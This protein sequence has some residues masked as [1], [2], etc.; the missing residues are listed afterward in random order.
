[1]SIKSFLI[2]QPIETRREKH[3]RLSKITG[4]AIFASD[5]LSSSA[6]ATEEIMLALI[7]AGSALLSFAVPIAISIAMLL[8]IIAVSYFQ[9]IHAYPSG[10]GA[11][12]VAKDNLGT[13]T[14]LVAGAA[15]LIDY[16][17]TVSVSIAAGVAA[18]TSA[19]PFL[20]EYR[21]LLGLIA[22]AGLM[23]GNLRG[24]REA[25]KMFFLPTY[26]FILSLF[27]LIIVG[28]VKAFTGT[29]PAPAAP[30]ETASDYIALFIILRAFASG[31]AAVTGIEAVSNG[32]R[33]FRPPE[34]RNASLT[35]IAMASILGTLFI[36]ISYLANHFHI[37][38]AENETM[39]SQLAALIFSKGPFYYSVQAATAMILILAANTS[40]QDFP[41]LSSVMA[42][43]GFMPRQ[44]GSRG[45]RLVFSNGIVILSLF[46]AAL[47]VLFKGDTHALI[48]LYAVGVFLAITLSQAGM[49]RHWLDPRGKR[50]LRNMLIN[51]MGATAT[52]V[53]TVIIAST[54]FIHGA[55]IVVIAIPILVFLMMKVN[56]HYQAVARQL[57][58]AGTEPLTEFDHHSVVV[59]VSGTQCAV[60]NAIRYAKV[61][62]D[63]VVAAYVCFDPIETDSVRE[64]WEKY[65]MDVPLVV[66]ESEFRSVI[67]PLMDY[68]DGVRAL[69]K[70]G[71]ITIVLPEFVPSK[72]WHH[73]LHNQTALLI[74]GMLLFKRGVVATSVPLHLAE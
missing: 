37:L 66:L 36:G 41:R 34:A 22:I 28:L 43:D 39:L 35:L 63:D 40:Y 69:H 9:T 4:L 52:A 55:W 5:N 1:M 27:G 74:K 50:W 57:S 38:P 20:Y 29:E 2:G 68:I 17:L 61:L 13:R 44:F 23:L 49:V 53:V 46:A 71:V 31:C 3:E 70:N 21:V 67:E 19:L 45:D 54:K 73:I 15:L 59:P 51:G 14:G 58:L 8:A 26:F 32:V 42:E 18:I 30:V 11:Y 72:W 65:G 12:I 25:G 48:P 62:S 56:R 64:K 6:Y 60:A 10:G 7:L 24:V 33:A 16:V 47:V